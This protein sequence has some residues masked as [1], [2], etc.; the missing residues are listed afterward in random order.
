MPTD[1]FEKTSWDWQLSQLRQQVS[2]WIEYE[3]SRFQLA[4]PE[5][6]QQWA[7]SPWLAKIL[8]FLFW[9]VV[10]GLLIWLA[11]LLWR[12]FRPYIYA[13][14]RSRGNNFANN[15]ATASNELSIGLLL[16]RS[17][18]FYRQGN[19]RE[20]CRSL[21]LALLQQLHDRSVIRHQPSRTDGEYLQLL[22]SSVT[23]IQ[24]YET[25]I[26]THEQLCFS[27]AEILP[28]NYEHCQQ[29]YREIAGE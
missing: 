5:W 12:E 1:S 6:P 15:P 14:L 16:E 27:N 9:L 4:L 8:Y 17:R 22:R 13:W 25:L 29:A 18:Q 10:G 26:T 19:Y 23:P 21:Y 2:E 7:I 28:E 24:P 20:A 11:W 3:F